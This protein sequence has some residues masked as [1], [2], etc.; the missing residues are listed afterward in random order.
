M[1]FIQPHHLDTPKTAFFLLKGVTSH[2]GISDTAHRLAETFTKRDKKVLIFDALLGLENYPTKSQNSDKIQSVLKGLSPL[3][4]IITTDKKIDIIAG[5]STQNLNALPPITQ[6]K[7]KSDLMLLSHNYDAVIIDCPATIVQP[8]FTN[9]EHTLWVTTTDL[10]TLLKTLR[11]AS[12]ETNPQIVLNNIKNDM[13]RNKA[14]LF[15]K[16]LL[17]ECQIIEFFE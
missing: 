14:H 8:L 4:D 5:T 9:M 15:I 17:P 11:T 10:D 12:Q 3:S 13:E 6:Q 2:V 7:I 16:D 1:P